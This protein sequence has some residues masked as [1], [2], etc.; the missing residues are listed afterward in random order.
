VR[1]LAGAQRILF[2]IIGNPPKKGKAKAEQGSVPDR[3]DSERPGWKGKEASVPSQESKGEISE[4]FAD[5]DGFRTGGIESSE[6][7]T[8]AQAGDTPIPWDSSPSTPPVAVELEY[9]DGRTLEDTSLAEPLHNLPRQHPQTEQEGTN[10]P[11]DQFA[12]A[13]AQVAAPQPAPVQAQVELARPAD[14]ARNNDAPDGRRGGFLDWFLGD[15]P[16]RI[17]DDRDDEAENGADDNGLQGA[18]AAGVPQALVEDDAAD[19]LEGIMELVGMRGPVIGLIQ[20]AAISS[21]LITVA[22]AL[23][24]AFPYVTGKTVMMVLAHP[25]IFFIRLPAQLMSWCAEVVIDTATMFGFSLLLIGEQFVKFFF[26]LV[27]H[28]VPSLSWFASNDSVTK[29]LRDWAMDGQRRVFGKFYAIETNYVAMRRYPPSPIPPLSFV[30]KDGLDRFHANFVWALGKVGLARIASA[31]FWTVP[32]FELPGLS[33]TNPVSWAVNVWHDAFPLNNLTQATNTTGIP[34]EIILDAQPFETMSWSAMD[35]IGVVLLGYAF[36]T[37]AGFIYTS[38][39][40]EERSNTGRL[41]V[42]FLHQCGGVMKVVLIIGIEMIVFPLYCGILLGKLSTR[43]HT[44]V[45]Y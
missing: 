9:P 25:F 20:N 3:G 35:R 40:R 19:D 30:V 11:D 34:E 32:Q 42:E 22:V 17:D 5:E 29:F 15:V 45:V 7:S 23:G 8:T 41:V 10:L 24:V 36:F 27:G 4:E 33:I 14:Q 6:W 44:C 1:A 31:A 16:E 38:R 43:C 12:G 28:V 2:E 39:R 37:A 18:V 13:G 21:V 26:Q